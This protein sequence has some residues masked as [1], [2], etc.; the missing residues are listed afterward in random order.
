[1][2]SEAIKKDNFDSL[3][4]CLLLFGA[5]CELGW[6]RER[7]AAFKLG[8]QIACRLASVA[9]LATFG[10]QFVTDL[11]LST[12]GATRRASFNWE[13]HVD[14]VM[15]KYHMV[16]ATG[17]KLGMLQYT[18]LEPT[19]SI[20]EELELLRFVDEHGSDKVI[21]ELHMWSG[22]RAKRR[23]PHCKELI[24]RLNSREFLFN[25]WL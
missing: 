20:S 22:S 19:G 5:A 23:N 14:E 24:D 8:I 18:D 4:F 10:K 9:P 16:I 11:A 1:L 15:D 12:L 2:L 6:N 7:E 3:S 25:P 21:Y 17:Y 13:K